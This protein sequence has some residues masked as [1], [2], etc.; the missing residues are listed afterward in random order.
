MNIKHHFGEREYAKEAQLLA[1]E[2]VVQ[3]RH[4]FA[5]LGILAAGTVELQRENE[6]KQRLTAPQC[7]L[8]PAG[9]HHAIR[10]LTDAVWYCVHGDPTGDREPDEVKIASDSHVE[11]MREMAESIVR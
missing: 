2:V 6:P 9:Q 4:N 8:I 1:G 3:H 10:A 11:T 7:V 5:H